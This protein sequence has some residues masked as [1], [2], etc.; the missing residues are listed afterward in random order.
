[1]YIQPGT[2]LQMNSDR[3][4]KVKLY[5]LLPTHMQRIIYK[6]NRLTN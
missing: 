1:M 6:V 3:W 4:P 5:S 2:A